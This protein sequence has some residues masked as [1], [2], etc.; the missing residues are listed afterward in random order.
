MQ[1][2]SYRMDMLNDDGCGYVE[3]SKEELQ[4]ALK[5]AKQERTRSI[6]MKMIED[7]KKTG[8][9]RYCCY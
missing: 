5:E 2:L 9:V 4:E 1:L 6:L 7:A 8:W 3:F